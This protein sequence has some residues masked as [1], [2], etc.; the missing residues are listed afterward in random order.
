MVRRIFL[1]LENEK[2]ERLLRIKGEK[3]WEKLLVDDLLEQEESELA[4]VK[5]REG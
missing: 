4:K 3:T 2:Y 1:V 5:V